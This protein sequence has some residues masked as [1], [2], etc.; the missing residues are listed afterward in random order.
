VNL[1]LR[2]AGRIFVTGLLTV[3]PLVLTLYFAIWLLTVLERFFGKQVNCSCPT[4]GTTRAWAWWSP[5][6]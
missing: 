1:A 2:R 4:T 5:S 6:C 3:L